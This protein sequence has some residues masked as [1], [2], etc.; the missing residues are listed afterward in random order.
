MDCYECDGP[1]RAGF[2]RIVGG[3]KV[4]LCGTC[5]RITPEY[6]GGN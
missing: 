2:S 6:K 5:E 3:N 1:I 4:W